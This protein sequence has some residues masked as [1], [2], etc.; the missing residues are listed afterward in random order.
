MFWQPHA[1]LSLTK[2]DVV[3]DAKLQTYI[4]Q[5]GSL[6][7]LDIGLTGLLKIYLFRL[8]ETAARFLSS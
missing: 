3:A 7:L 1:C 6:R 2:P 4:K 8:A 5:R